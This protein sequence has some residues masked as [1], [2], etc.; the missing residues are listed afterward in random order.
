M[1]SQAAWRN[2]LRFPLFPRLRILLMDKA[3]FIGARQRVDQITVYLRS[4]RH[5]DQI[6]IDVAVNTGVGRQFYAFGRV[7][8]ALDRT[9]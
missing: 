3:R 1:V 4:H 7:Y 5:L 6:V 8:V 9:I 2:P